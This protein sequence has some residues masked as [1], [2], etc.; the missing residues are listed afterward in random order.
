MAKTTRL[1][2]QDLQIYPSQR[3]TDTDDGGGR[4]VGR[5]LTG[6]DNEVFPPVSDVDRTMGSFDARLL[7]PA[8][9]RDDQEPLYGGHFIISEPPQAANVSFLAFKARNYGETR[10]DIMPRIAAYSVPTIEG[11]MTLMG[12]HLAGVRLIQAY[13]RVEAPLPKIGE[14]YC[15]QFR[16]KNSTL[17]ARYEYFRIANL[18]HEV[19]TFEVPKGNG[20]IKEIQRRVLKMEIGNPLAYDY[21]GVNYPQEGYA[22][23]AGKI[24]ETQ[25]ADSASYYGVKPLAAAIRKGDAELAV[26]GIYEKLVPTSTVETPHADLY[27]VQ[28]EQWVATG[29][30]RTVFSTRDTVEGTLHLPY[31]LLPGSVKVN[32]YTDNARG[33]L[34]G[35]GQSIQVDYERGRLDGIPQSYGLTVS[36][37]AAAKVSGSRYATHIEIK[38]SN[39]GTAWAP[40]LAPAPS[41]GSL[42]VSY[43]SLGV[44]YE[45]RDYGD[46]VLRT[47]TGEAAGSV[48][49]SGSVILNLPA[50][51]DIGSRIVLQW[52]DADAYRTFDAKKAGQTPAITRV[53]G[54]VRLPSVRGGCIK[55]GTYT[56]SWGGKSARDSNGRITG[57]A[58]GWM[59]Y[60]DGGAMVRGIT[61]TAVQIGYDEYTAEEVR[62]QI[63]L[64][65]DSPALDATIGRTA[66]GSLVLAILYQAAA[67][68]S[69]AKW[70]KLL[71]NG[72]SAGEGFGDGT[73]AAAAKHDLLIAKS[74]GRYEGM[75]LVKITDNGAGR[76]MA[77]DVLLKQGSIDYA[78]GRII[79]P[80]PVTADIPIQVTL[81]NGQRATVAPGAK[82]VDYDKAGNPAVLTK[83][84]AGLTVSIKQ[85]AFAR[86][87][88]EGTRRIAKTETPSN[89]S[90]NVLK[91]MAGTAV[92]NSWTFKLG[93]KEI[94]ERNGILL[95]D[96]DVKRGTGRVVGRLGEGGILTFGDPDNDYGG[97]SITGGIVNRL[98]ARQYAYGGR[99]VSAPVKPE[100]FTVYA[101]AGGGTVLSGRSDA[102]GNIN[103]DFTGKIDY[104]TGFYDINRTDGFSPDSL[105]YNAVTQDNIPLDSGI[106]G[107]DAVRLPADGRVPVFRKGDMVVIGNR[108][109]QDLGRAFTGGQVISL[110]RNKLDRVCLSDAAGKH[111][112]AEQYAVDLDAG[113]LTLADPLNLSGHTLPLTAVLAWEEENR[114]TAVDISGRLK[115]QFPVSRDYPKDGTYVSSAL[116]AGDLLVRH[117][118]PFSQKS[119]GGV[120]SD[121][122]IGDPI[123]AK[124]NLADYPLK[125]ASDGAITERWLIRFISESQYQLYGE[126][127]GLVVQGDTVTDLAPANPAT[128]K[129]YFR[130]PAAAFGGGWAAQNCIRINT[131]GTPMPVWVLRAVQPAAEKQRGRDGF[132]ACLR[133][134]TVAE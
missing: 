48:A 25:V 86:I 70:A 126:N 96:W 27:P 19:R 133:G 56:L 63:T 105:R 3:M 129:P 34:V 53:D 101:L 8:V 119:W 29:E 90:A 36:A 21:E 30:E 51:P 103:G 44:W 118:E 17:P 4:M 33:Q 18:E 41:A 116:I 67:D 91:D 123:L 108:V 92:F 94:V 13:Q 65:G 11:R 37:R 68:S 12:R 131:Y 128:G 88:S 1:T 122:L 59:R 58:E 28:S 81:N 110:S 84:I 5:P 64:A 74:A 45:L 46:Y 16:E 24:L 54:D 134:N 113:K 82:V 78:T 72:R 39:Q 42:T 125:L 69:T 50:R 127:V 40:L 114:I 62:G 83:T 97:L 130:L 43:M 2:Q 109:K 132:T 80:D 117:S 49:D 10:A 52:G 73:I 7:Y 98:A 9:L 32:G 111:I 115:L 23:I 104:E 121:S 106:I 66:P 38:D 99:T 71:Y 6:A 124:L 75:T 20:E 87:P 26:T 35:N 57:D 77:D 15:L 107:I 60:A 112:L 89:I 31:A 47:E 76:L 14:R 100:S 22:D 93:D 55:P 95:A 85:A 102:D 61:A 79:L 120:W